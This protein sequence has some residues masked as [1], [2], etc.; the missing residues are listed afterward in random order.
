[1]AEYLLRL[2]LM[3]EFY[4]IGF[5]WVTI[6]C[7]NSSWVEYR[8]VPISSESLNDSVSKVYYILSKENNVFCLALLYAD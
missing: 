6:L 2:L 8:L 7:L 5:G 3:E 4:K 1:M